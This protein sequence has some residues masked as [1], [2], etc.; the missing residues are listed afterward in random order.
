MDDEELLTR[1]IGVGAFPA[2][3]KHGTIVGVLPLMHEV[4]DD[5]SQTTVGHVDF[6]ALIAGFTGETIVQDVVFRGP[7]LEQVPDL[8]VVGIIELKRKPFHVPD[9]KVVAL[10]ITVAV[11]GK[12]RGFDE[13]FAFGIGTRQDAVFVV[14][15]VA[16]SNGQ[17]FSFLTNAG[18]IA[19]RNFCA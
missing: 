11:M 10:T 6:V 16:P 13:N 18:P 1:V 14:M 3:R 19:I 2:I 9:I 12:L 15:K 7:G 5:V 4:A 17:V 8:G